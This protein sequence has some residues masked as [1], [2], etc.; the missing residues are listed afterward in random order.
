MPTQLTLTSNGCNRE[1]GKGPQ[2]V[3]SKASRDRNRCR[4]ARGQGKTCTVNARLRKPQVWDLSQ[5]VAYQRLTRQ[6]R[7]RST[8]RV[9]LLPAG[10]CQCSIDDL[11]PVTRTIPHR[12]VKDRTGHLPTSYLSNSVN[13]GSPKRT[14]SWRSARR[15]SHHTSQT[16]GVMSGTAAEG[17][18]VA[19]ETSRVIGRRKL[20]HWVKGGVLAET[21]NFITTRG[22]APGRR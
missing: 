7:V 6:C 11:I 15:R 4:L 21:N 2:H 12:G 1:T 18:T 5:V 10:D 19:S 16:P 14:P 9:S 8:D 20:A 13:T 22:G 3:E 17:R